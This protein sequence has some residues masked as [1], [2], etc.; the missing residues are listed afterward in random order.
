[1][2]GARFEFDKKD[3]YKD[4]N[5][6]YDYTSIM[7]YG[8]FDFSIDGRPTMKARKSSTMIRP[9]KRLSE[10]DVEE[11]RRMYNCPTARTKLPPTRDFP[12]DDDDETEQPTQNY[13]IDDEDLLDTTTTKTTTTKKKTTIKLK[14]TRK[15]SSPVVKP[16]RNYPTDDEDL[17]PATTTTK[18]TVVKKVSIKWTGEDIYII[19]EDN[20]PDW[21]VYNSSNH[22]EI[23]KYSFVEYDEKKNVIL[24]DNQL[25]VYFRLT[26]KA[27]LFSK[28]KNKNYAIFQSGSWTEKSE[29]TERSKRNALKWASRD[30]YIENRPLNSSE[31]IV[32]DRNNNNEPV[33]RLKFFKYDGNDVVLKHE[34]LKRFYKLTDKVL[35]WSTRASSNFV[36]LKPGKWEKNDS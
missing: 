26:D 3:N 28:S 35:L 25:K 31:W 15:S 16:T 20:K 24:K 29:E 33:Q 34:T 6:S 9:G 18:K 10:I 32:F 11:I 30:W 21:F 4:L 19:N 14:S 27:I 1:L 7:H 23:Y 8:V 36:E 13:P 12:I 17:D 22:E 2:I 5:T